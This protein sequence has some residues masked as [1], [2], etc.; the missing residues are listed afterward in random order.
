VVKVPPEL[1]WCDLLDV[2]DRYWRALAEHQDACQAAR[3]SAALGNGPGCYGSQADSAERVFREDY[4][5]IAGLFAD[6]GYASHHHRIHAGAQVG[7]PVA[8]LAALMD[9]HA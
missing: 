7:A 5:R 6:C 3:G 1:V 8:Q 2:T 9:R 4:A